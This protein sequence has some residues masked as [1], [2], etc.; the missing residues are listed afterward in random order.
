[1]AQLREDIRPRGMNNWI[2]HELLSK[3]LFNRGFSSGQGT[4]DAWAEQCTNG[5]DDELVPR[6]HV[7]CYSWPMF[8]QRS[9]CFVV[10]G[11][12]MF[13]HRSDSLVVIGILADSLLR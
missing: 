4:F 10:I 8:S 5:S 11:I 3:E 13:S 6:F 12:P 7:T 9:D 1:M 2:S